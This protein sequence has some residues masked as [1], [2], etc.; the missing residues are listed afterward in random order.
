MWYDSPLRS[1]LPKE[2]YADADVIEKARAMI[3]AGGADGF[4][5]DYL[6]MAAGQVTAI[7]QALRGT[8]RGRPAASIPAVDGA[9]DAAEAEASRR[10]AERGSAAL[11]AAIRRYLVRHHAPAAKEA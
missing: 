1:S 10:D 5:S 2:V 9:E 8:A 4:V 11:L 7:R 3:R 6:G